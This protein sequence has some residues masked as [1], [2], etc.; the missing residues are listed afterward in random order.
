MSIFKNVGYRFG[1]SVHR[2]TTSMQCGK[3]YTTS[4]RYSPPILLLLYMTCS[5]LSL[6]GGVPRFFRDTPRIK[7]R[8]L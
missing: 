7:S 8:L 2:P 5:G 1:I 4:V 6:I 3:N